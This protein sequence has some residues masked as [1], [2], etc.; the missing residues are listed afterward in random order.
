M[1]L[2]HSVGVAAAIDKASG[3]VV[4]TESRKMTCTGNILPT[5]NAVATSAGGALKCKFVVHAVGPIADQ[6][7]HQCVKECLYKCYKC[8][9]KL[10]LAQ[11][12]VVS[13]LT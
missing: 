10:Q 2:L 7:K 11:V 8:S 9:S 13:Q 5:G 3:G 6:H 4:Q 1:Y 12:T